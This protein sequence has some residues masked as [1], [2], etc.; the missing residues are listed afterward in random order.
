MKPLLLVTLVS[1]PAVA[2]ESVLSKLSLGFDTVGAIS[3]TQARTQ[4]GIGG[5]VQAAF[6]FD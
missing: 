2:E 6:A 3:L 1:L 4:G 5:G